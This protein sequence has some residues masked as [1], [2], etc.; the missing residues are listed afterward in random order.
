MT[1]SSTAQWKTT[2]ALC[3]KTGTA[4]A[5]AHWP[6]SRQP[7]SMEQ[8]QECMSA[9]DLNIQQRPGKSQSWSEE[10]SSPDLSSDRV[11][12]WRVHLAEPSSTDSISSVLSSDEL[13]RASRS[14]FEKDRLHFLDAARRCAFCSADISEFQ[15]RKYASNVSLAGA[16]TGCTTNQ[17]GSG[18]TFRTP[19]GWH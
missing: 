5:T 10:S 3:Q 19:P 7:A 6:Q 17:R 8:E 13:T 11:D 9:V 2:R 4:S 16:G 15:P 18:S 14:Y 1:S 12:V